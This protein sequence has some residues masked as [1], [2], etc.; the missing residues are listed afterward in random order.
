[1]KKVDFSTSI[2]QKNKFLFLLA[3][4]KTYI[5]GQ[6]AGV[7]VHYAA[8]PHA[9]GGHIS[10]IPPHYIRPFSGIPTLLIGDPGQ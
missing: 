10:G 9:Q 8:R 4:P 7:P 6:E 5:F 1:M 2:N 3:R